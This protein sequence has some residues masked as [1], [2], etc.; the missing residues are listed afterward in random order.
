MQITISGTDGEIGSKYAWVG[1]PENTGSGKMTT[2]AIKPN[3]EI[4]YNLHFLVPYESKAD[5]YVG[6]SKTED[7][8]TK[9]VWGFYGDNQFPFNIVMLFMD[10]EDMMASDFDSGLNM[11]KDMSEKQFQAAG[12]YT[13]DQIE[14]PGKMFATVR[15]VE[16]TNQL[17]DFFTEAYRQIGKAQKKSR[18]RITGT[19]CAL[20]YKWDEPNQR[21]DVAA[22]MPV[23][24]DMKSEGINMVEVPGQRAYKVDYYGP[25][26]KEGLGS[27]H[28]ALMLH[29]W[30]NDLTMAAPFI[31]EYVTGPQTE[32]D[33]S[34]WLTRIYYFAE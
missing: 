15:K 25:Y 19:A 1:D 5:G 22:A 11:L 12:R 33:A 2:T 17:P 14:W 7:E 28:M 23:N 27:A 16:S 6:V 29:F 24:R 10:M 18:A 30:Q 3:E 32:S 20:Y 8:K 4:A 9:A 34:K 13:V 21:A 31:E 26:E